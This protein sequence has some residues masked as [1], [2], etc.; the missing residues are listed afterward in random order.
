MIF[1]ARHEHFPV[2][3]GFNGVVDAAE[4]PRPA[5]TAI[6]LRVRSEQPLIASGANERSCAML[7]VERNGEAPLRAFAP[8]HVVLVSRQFLPPLFVEFDLL[9]LRLRLAIISTMQYPI[10]P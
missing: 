6:K 2:C 1:S 9:I 3:F 7:V 8:Q 5:G 10:A 4:K